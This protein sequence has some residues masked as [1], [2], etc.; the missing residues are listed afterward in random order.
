MRIGILGT[1]TM[2]TALAE[3]W[4][5]AGEHSIL[6]GGR[7]IQAATGAAGRLGDNVAAATPDR[8]VAG[9]DIVVVAVAWE[10]LDTIL[11]LANASGRT[12]ASKTILDCTN[13]VDYTTGSLKPDA[14]SAAQHIADVVGS[15]HV[16]KALHL[17]AGAS[18]LAPPPDEQPV[19]SVAVCGGEPT[20][21]AR[22][23]ELIRDLG[24]VPVNI[25]GLD[26]AR[27]LEDVAGFVIRLVAAGCNPTTAVPFVHPPQT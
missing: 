24:G 12:F 25:G 11:S 13:S 17:F 18:W 8:V 15:K 19:R 21:L 23:S 14:G 3:A 5:R 26:H 27:Q 10:G 20:D 6:I 4:I 2:A 1:G 7:S 16:V 22:V 9:S